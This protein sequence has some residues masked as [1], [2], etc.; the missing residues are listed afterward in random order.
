MLLL[1]TV[2]TAL[3]AV[4]CLAFAAWSVAAGKLVAALFLLLLGMLFG[5]LAVT[6][7]YAREKVSTFREFVGW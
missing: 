4:V 3:V 5:A 1:W 6:A 7:Y 2:V